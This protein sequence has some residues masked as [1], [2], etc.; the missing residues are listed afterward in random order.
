MNTTK[1]TAA[2]CW[3]GWLVLVS[4]ASACNLEESQRTQTLSLGAQVADSLEKSFIF[5]DVVY[6]PQGNTLALSAKSAPGTLLALVKTSDYIRA[7]DLFEKVAYLANNDAGVAVVD[8]SNPSAPVRLQQLPASK[9]YQ[10]MNVKV[11][12][13]RLY[14]VE[15]NLTVKKWNLLVYTL[16]NPLSPTFLASS[17]LGCHASASGGMM[18][19]LD[20]QHLAVTF[21][22]EGIAVYNVARAGSIT[23]VATITVAGQSAMALHQGRLFV[24]SGLTMGSSKLT[25]WD[26]QNPAAPILLGQRLLARAAYD[27]EANLSLG[28]RNGQL[29]A[30][31]GGT[32]GWST[33]TMIIVNVTSNAP[34]APLYLNL[35]NPAGESI[36]VADIDVIGKTAWIS[37]WKVPVDFPAGYLYWVLKVDISDPSLPSVVD[38]V[39]VPKQFPIER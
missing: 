18:V 32:A 25:V 23:Q 26:V 8:V 39:R 5:S 20:D 29:Y 9:G 14:V 11:A 27:H 21:Y 15:W 35:T 1:K 31:L 2:T 6:T 24:H 16:A 12:H 19:A 33:E 10:T 28:I 17:S 22:V 34:G 38:A 7:F 4:L 3:I 37:G 36:T 13:N 30:F